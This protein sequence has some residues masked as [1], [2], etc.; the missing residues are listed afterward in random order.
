MVVNPEFFDNFKPI[1]LRQLLQH[2]WFNEANVYEINNEETRTQYLA[3]FKGHCS[4]F[5]YSIDTYEP[6]QKYQK[7]STLLVKMFCIAGDNVISVYV[8]HKD[9]EVG[10]Q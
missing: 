7:I 8:Y 2:A 5:F 9:M 10:K 6:K 4:N 1:E 3:I